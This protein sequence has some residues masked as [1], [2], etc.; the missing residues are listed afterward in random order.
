MYRCQLKRVYKSRM[1]TLSMFTANNFIV[2]HFRV[3]PEAQVLPSLKESTQTGLCLKFKSYAVFLLFTAIKAIVPG[4]GLGCY[5][6][7]TPKYPFN[8]L[9]NSILAPHTCTRTSQLDKTTRSS[10]HKHKYMHMYIIT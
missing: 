10:N 4:I 3:W 9:M 1:Y 2:S 5:N 8:F 7:F 6:W